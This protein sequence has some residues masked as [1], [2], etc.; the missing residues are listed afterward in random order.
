MIKEA[1]EKC[2]E[3]MSLMKNFMYTAYEMS[4]ADEP[5]AEKAIV[6]EVQ[7]QND[8]GSRRI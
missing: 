1:R 3:Q 8:A 5:K 4:W 7:Q 2:A 6:R